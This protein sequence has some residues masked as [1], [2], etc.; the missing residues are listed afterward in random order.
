MIC[1]FERLIDWQKVVKHHG[2]NRPLSDDQ[3]RVID[4]NRRQLKK[5]IDPKSIIRRLYEKKCFNADHNEHIECAVT[6][7]KKVG[8]LLA[9]VRRRS[10]ASFKNLVVELRTD[11]Q[12]DAANVLDKGGGNSVM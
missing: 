6:N 1:L 5:L 11:K 12:F 8:R 7:F 2:D 4:V 3:Q 9:I 10:V